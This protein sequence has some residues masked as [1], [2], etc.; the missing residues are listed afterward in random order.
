MAVEVLDCGEVPLVRRVEGAGVEE[1][2]VCFVAVE[3]WLGC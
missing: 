2:G 3:N 1:E